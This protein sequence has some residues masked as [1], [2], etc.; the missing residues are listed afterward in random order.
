MSQENVCGYRF[1]ERSPE[2][3]EIVKALIAFKLECPKVKAGRWNDISKSKYANLSDIDEVVTPLLLKRGLV[4]TQLLSADQF[5]ATC[6]TVLLH[7]SGQYIASS[8]TMTAHERQGMQAP[9]AKPGHVAAALGHAKANGLKGILALAFDDEK[10]E[11]REKE[12]KQSPQRVAPPPPPPP[13]RP[14]QSQLYD[15]KAKG[16]LETLSAWYQKHN[17]DN[18]L[19]QEIEMRLR[20][21]PWSE[22]GAIAREVAKN[23]PY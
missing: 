1:D 23:P 20:G 8:L 16:H 4:Y 19:Y 22:L 17:I 14:D 15:H 21:K 3:G 13:P 10:S 6:K 9:S 12:K 5:D 18:R 7:E 11:P 2:I